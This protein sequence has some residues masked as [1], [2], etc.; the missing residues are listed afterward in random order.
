MQGN[1][2]SRFHADQA[3]GASPRQ[4]RRG[5]VAETVECGRGSTAARGEVDARVNVLIRD[6]S[7]GVRRSGPDVVRV[8]GGH[9]RGPHLAQRSFAPLGLFVPDHQAAHPRRHQQVDDHRG[10][11][12]HGFVR[13]VSSDELDRSHHGN[14]QGRRGE[15]H[16]P[17]PLETIGVSPPWLRQ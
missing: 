8:T 1:R 6:L 16:E 14:H 3:D 15:Q 17:R 10:R 7:D 5:H 12:Q 11:D 2:E 4:I 13:C 9:E